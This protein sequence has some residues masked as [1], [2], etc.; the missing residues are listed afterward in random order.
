MSVIPETRSVDSYRRVNI[1]VGILDSFEGDQGPPPAFQ[2]AVR[3]GDIILSPVSREGGQT[4]TARNRVR[5]PPEVADQY[6]DGE[7][8]AVLEDDDCIVLKP[9]DDINISI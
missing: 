9:A 8:F 6:E 7:E 4:L 1:P 2:V 5:L 3:D